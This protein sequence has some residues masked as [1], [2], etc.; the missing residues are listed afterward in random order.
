M[1]HLYYTSSVLYYGFIFKIMI[2]KINN[3]NWSISSRILINTNIIKLWDIISSPSNLE[4]Y[5]PFC[6][7]NQVIHWSE[8]ESVDQIIYLN[9]KTFERKF[10]N[11]YPNSGYDLIINQIGKSDSLV[12]W[13]IISVD[14]KSEIEIK[15][16][17]Y[18]FNQGKIILNIIPFKFIS[19]PLLTTYLDSVT[20]GLKYYAETGNVVSKNQFG[21]NLWFS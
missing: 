18:I 19:K 4:L 7:K 1:G 9:G 21:K 17:P 8:E 14:N 11:W 15:V 16:Y 20:I 2:Q 3:Y 10:F 12:K 13:R 5:H 6:L